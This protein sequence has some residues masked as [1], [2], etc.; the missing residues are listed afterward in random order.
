MS[1]SGSHSQEEYKFYESKSSS[2]RVESEEETVDFNPLKE[3][4]IKDTVDTSKNFEHEVEGLDNDVEHIQNSFI[5][6]N[7]NKQRKRQLK[8]NDKKIEH[9]KMKQKENFYIDLEVNEES[10]EN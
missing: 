4:F 5:K 2:F 1:F 9:N 6:K 10:E 8:L 7:S 3:L